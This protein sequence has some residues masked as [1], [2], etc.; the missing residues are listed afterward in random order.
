MD[1]NTKRPDMLPK[2]DDEETG[3]TSSPEAVDVVD[4]ENDEGSCMVT[5]KRTTSPP[6]VLLVI[7]LGAL[8]AQRIRGVKSRACDPD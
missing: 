3:D 8:W 7:L 1:P 2:V 6:L 5:G 4:Y